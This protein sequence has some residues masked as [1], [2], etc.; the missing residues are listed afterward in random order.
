LEQRLRGPYLHRGI[1]REA[2]RG[3]LEQ[4]RGVPGT[5]CPFVE[6]GLPKKASQEQPG[7]VLGIATA[8]A[9]APGVPVHELAAELAGLEDAEEREQ[10]EPGGHERHRPD[11]WAPAKCGRQEPEP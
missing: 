10:A 2:P 9:D 7:D 1:V 6:L 3:K 5:A 8:D 4:A 11:D